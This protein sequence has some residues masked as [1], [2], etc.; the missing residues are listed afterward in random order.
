[1]QSVDALD[2][3]RHYLLGSEIHI[4]TEHSALRYLQNQARPSSSQTRWLE[5]LQ[6]YS[7]LNI[8]HIHDKTNTAADGMSRSHTLQEEVIEIGRH[9]SSWTCHSFGRFGS[10]RT[11]NF[12]FPTVGTR[13][14][15]DGSHGGLVDGLHQRRYDQEG[16]FHP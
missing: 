6:V 12:I 15:G 4:F 10:R 11:I 1:M 3:W 5:K 14:S 8:A 16:L 7:L 13:T 9:P 2:D